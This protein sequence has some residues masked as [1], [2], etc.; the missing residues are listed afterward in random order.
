MNY[1]RIDEPKG[2]AMIVRH[3]D[4]VDGLLPKDMPRELMHLFTR[5]LD[6]EPIQ[7]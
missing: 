4:P 3:D 7:A 6:I 5:F 1:F 2:R